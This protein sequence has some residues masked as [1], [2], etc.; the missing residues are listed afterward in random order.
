ML[1]TALMTA[2]EYGHLEVVIDLISCGADIN[3]QNKV[4]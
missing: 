3:I 4:T 1:N 2:A